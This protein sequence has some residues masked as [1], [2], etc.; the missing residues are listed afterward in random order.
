[1]ITMPKKNPHMYVMFVLSLQIELEVP[2]AQVLKIF[3]YQ[4]CFITTS[5]RI[6]LES[7][8]PIHIENFPIGP[9]GQVL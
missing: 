9:I 4:L 6:D 7:S 8:S 3:I 5:K 2:V 1:M